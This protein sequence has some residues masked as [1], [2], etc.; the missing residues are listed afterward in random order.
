M[1]KRG[2][3]NRK[4]RWKMLKVRQTDGNV[5]KMIDSHRRRPVNSRCT[6]EFSINVIYKIV[7]ACEEQFKERPGC[8]S[9]ISTTCRCIKWGN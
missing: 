9:N 3:G 5:P 8:A 7:E 1:I 4:S 6:Y 2:R